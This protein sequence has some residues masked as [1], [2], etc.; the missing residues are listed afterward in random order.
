MH[1]V[2]LFAV[3]IFA[4]ALFAAAT[5]TARELVQAGLDP[6][7][8]YR[9]RD[10]HFAADR[11]K[12]FFTDGYL[13]LG[14]QVSG[15][16]VTA[17]FT[18]DVEGGDAEVLLLPPNRAERQSLAAYTESPNLDEHFTTA[19][20]LFSPEI[21]AQFTEQ[22]QSSG[23]RKAPEMGAL[24]DSKYSAVAR[25]IASSF[26]VRLT[27]SLLAPESNRGFFEALIS[28]KTLGNFDVEYRSPWPPSKSPLGPPRSATIRPSSI[29]GP[30][31][32]P[33]PAPRRVS[34][35]SRCYR[36]P[37]SLRPFIRTSRSTPVTR[38][39][40]RPPIP[41]KTSCAPPKPGRQ[42]PTRA[43][44]PRGRES[45]RRAGAPAWRGAQSSP[46]KS[47]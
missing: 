19:F 12:F 23:V 22:I 20:L 10:L 41:G 24:L 32:R 2:R 8:C 36:T 18:T 46:Q 17:F 39:R 29:H 33:A 5:D 26:D 13:I 21:L 35:N 9:V 3:L 28:G 1:P 45:T 15:Q 30:A 34:R 43:P 31:L 37:G 6:G 47:A 40:I 4:P 44:A 27:W 11:A 42:R 16:R 14:R 38:Y 7:E 25:N